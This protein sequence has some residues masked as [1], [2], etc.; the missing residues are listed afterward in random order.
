M[1]EPEGVRA[2][3]FITDKMVRGVYHFDLQQALQG[4]TGSAT[5][6]RAALLRLKRKQRLAEPVRGFFVIVPPEYRR[7]GCLPAEQFIPH[8]MEFWGEPYY[9]ALLS[10]AE[11][12]GAAHQRP[13][14]FQVML[15]T[16]RR[17]LRCGKVQVE[18][19][20]R[21]DAADTSVVKKTTPR[22]YLRVA[23]P[24]ATAVELIGYHDRAGGLSNVA[25]VLVELAE[26]IDPEVLAE[27]ARRVPLSWI[28]RL[29]YLLE[30][31]GEEELADTLYPFASK[32]EHPAPL[33]RS[34]PRGGV[35]EDA[36]W[37]VLINVDVEPDL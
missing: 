28:Q 35:P 19:M 8:L 30:S 34:Y 24:A 27:E 9:A 26:V 14:V 37:K 23:T 32:A 6:V 4:I 13:Q 29:G 33:V 18:F 25:T 20:A 31:I 21:Q 2:E 17:P 3:D 16:N 11:L 5:A 12:H 7:I 10:A 15:R 1:T 36:R 22:G